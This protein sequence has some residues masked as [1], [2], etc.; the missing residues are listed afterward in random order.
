MQ[1]R[2][3]DLVIEE[4]LVLEIADQHALAEVAQDCLQPFFL[5]FDPPR[6]R[7][8]RVL[9]LALCRDQLSGKLGDGFG[10]RAERAVGTNAHRRIRL[11]LRHEPR[12]GGQTQ[13]WP[14]DDLLDQE[15]DEAKRADQ[16]ERSA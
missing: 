1:Q 12:L 15:P 5:L 11:C 14:D 2:E 9:D 3:R 4:D 10:Q 8:D 16:R 13:R 6:G 7:R